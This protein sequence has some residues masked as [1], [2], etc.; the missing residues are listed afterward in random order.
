[1]T[2][3]VVNTCVINSSKISRNTILIAIT[4]INLKK[5][6]VYI[7]YFRVPGSKLSS[8]CRHNFPRDYYQDQAPQFPDC[9]TRTTCAADFLSLVSTVGNGIP[10]PTLLSDPCQFTTVD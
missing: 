5:G 9:I 6:S 2:H 10:W 7:L 1:M 3:C 8:H 4:D